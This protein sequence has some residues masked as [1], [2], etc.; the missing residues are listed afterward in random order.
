MNVSFLF[1]IGTGAAVASL[2]ITK[3]P[4]R[5]VAL[6][7]CMGCYAIGGAEIGKAVPDEKILIKKAPQK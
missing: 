1:L 5:V 6:V 3:T 2:F 4:F 7:I